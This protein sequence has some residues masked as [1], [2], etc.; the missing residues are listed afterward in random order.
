MIRAERL[1]QMETLRGKIQGKMHQRNQGRLYEPVLRGS[2]ET[3]GDE[4]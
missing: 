3:R 2:G 4:V 1:L